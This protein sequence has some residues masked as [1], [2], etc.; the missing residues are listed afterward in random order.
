M[1][2]GHPAGPGQPGRRRVRVQRHRFALSGRAGRRRKAHFVAVQPPGVGVNRGR[3]ACRRQIGGEE[4]PHRVLAN[5][6]RQTLHGHRAPAEAL[7]TP[8]AIRRSQIE[9]QDRRARPRDR[10]GD[11]ANREGAAAVDGHVARQAQHVVGRGGRP[12]RQRAPLRHAHHV[13]GLVGG[14]ERR[15]VVGGGHRIHRDRHP[16]WRRRVRGA[17]EELGQIEPIARRG[18]LGGR[19]DQEPR[20]VGPVRHRG[21]GEVGRRRT[22]VESHDVAIRAVRRVRR[23]ELEEVPAALAVGARRGRRQ[24]AHI[25]DDRLN[26][27]GRSRIAERDGD[28]IGRRARRTKRHPEDDAQDRHRTGDKGARILHGDGA[29]HGEAGGPATRRHVHDAPRRGIQEVPAAERD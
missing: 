21:K 28:R 29:S 15:A 22:N 13:L 10:C 11:G 17:V 14:G 7:Q 9:F 4:R 6:A 3:H 8:H 12:E 1:G 2:V 25:R 23:R 18:R 20:D 26:V 27:S 16:R 5:R 19:G 24:V